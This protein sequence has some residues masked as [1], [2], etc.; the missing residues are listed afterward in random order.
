[1]ALLPQTHS[2]NAPTVK[3]L[4]SVTE[5]FQQSR[6]KTMLL[7]VER[8]ELHQIWPEHFNTVGQGAAEL[9]CDDSIN[10]HRPVL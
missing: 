7:K 8:F 9:F 5:L 3:I 1:M 2:H 10:F 4:L 6:I